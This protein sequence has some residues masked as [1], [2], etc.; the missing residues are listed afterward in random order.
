MGYN[1]HNIVDMN[2]GIILSTGISTNPDDHKDFITQFEQYEELYGPIPE[3]THLVADNGYYN[4]ENL[5]QINEKQWNAYIPNRELATL[6]K[7]KAK[8]N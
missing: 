1:I 4:E 2:S 3:T 8:M 7:K 5:K 6:F